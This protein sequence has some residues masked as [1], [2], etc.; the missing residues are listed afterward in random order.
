MRMRIYLTGRICIEAGGVLLD[1]PRF[2]GRQG[3]LVFAYL[4]TEHCRAVSHEELAEELWG[5]SLPPTWERTLSAIVSKLRSLLGLVGLPGGA[6]ASAFGRYQLHLPPASW[7]DL[8]AA[9]EAVDLAEG[10]HRAG[11]PQRAWGWGQ[12]AFQIARR[13]F[14]AGE[15]GPWA[16]RRQADL[17]NVLL[18]TLDCLSDICLWNAEPALAV[19]H[20]EQAVTLD[21]FRETSYQRLMRA[22][23]AAGNRAQAL[24][25]YERC[26]HLLS[27]DLGVSPSPQTEAVYLEIL[28]A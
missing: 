11:E 19:R 12:I 25:I 23:A 7:V 27:E 2:Q 26:Q 3:R 17:Q 24:R 21:P 6:L 22:H 8:E 1:E 4:A 28:R 9:A 16:A 14:L 13:P 15:E 10:A 20:A 5:D 18:R